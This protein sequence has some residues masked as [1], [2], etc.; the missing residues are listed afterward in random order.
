MSAYPTTQLPATITTLPVASHATEVATRQ[1]GTLALEPGQAEWTERQRAALDQLGLSEA[2]QGDMAVFLHQSQRTQ[3]DPFAR[4]IYMIGRWDSEL[5]RKKW[6]IQTAIDGFRIVAERHGQYGGQVGP[7]WC[8]EDGQWRDVWVSTKPP[9]AAR[10]GIIRKDW[11][12]PIYATAHFHEYAGTTKAG[13]LTRMWATK[14]AVMISKCAEALALRKAFPHDLSGIYTAEEMSEREVT[15]VPSERADR[16]PA[17][18]AEEPEPPADWDA[19]LKRRAGNRDAL[20]DLWNRARQ[21]EPDNTEL[22]QRIKQAGQAASGATADDPVGAVVATPAEG[23]GTD[24][25][26]GQEA[27][28]YGVSVE[29]RRAIGQC[30]LRLGV[31]SDHHQAALAGSLVNRQIRSVGAL[32]STEADKVVA[33]LENLTDLGEVGRDTIANIIATAS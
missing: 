3:L 22:Q 23:A 27:S 15:Q 9:I 21:V 12:Q 20:L 29:Q 14:P 33:E 8:G 1:V 24:T 10:V 18:P 4:Q 2:P 19:E 32:T 16:P 30:L 26:T 25:P 5:G 7:E 13:N 28:G 17:Q 11:A 31:N 6:T